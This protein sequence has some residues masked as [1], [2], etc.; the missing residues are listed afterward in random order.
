MG[1]HQTDDF[2]IAQSRFAR[3]PTCEYHNESAIATAAWAKSACAAS[4][5]PDRMAWQAWSMKT[6]ALR[7]SQPAIIPEVEDEVAYDE[8][9]GIAHRIEVERLQ[10]CACLIDDRRKRVCKECRDLLIRERTARPHGVVVG[11]D[12]RQGLPRVRSIQIESDSDRRIRRRSR[13]VVR[14]RRAP[15]VDNKALLH[16][17]FPLLLVQYFLLP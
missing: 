12:A 2:I 15:F 6:T 5:C 14:C 16:L 9:A 17:G 7:E 1:S 13:I 3:L 8:A 10:R 11:S 4:F